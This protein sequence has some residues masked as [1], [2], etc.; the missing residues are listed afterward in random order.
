MKIIKCRRLTCAT[1][2]MSVFEYG[3]TQTLLFTHI[4]TE[5]E[6]EFDDTLFFYLKTC[7]PKKD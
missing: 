1:V 3:D 4:Y 6:G 7:E 5:K 2:C